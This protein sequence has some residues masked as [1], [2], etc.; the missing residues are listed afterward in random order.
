MLLCRPAFE[1][2]L[3]DQILKTIRLFP[4]A[5]YIYECLTDDN[6][7]NIKLNH[8]Q[9]TALKLNDQIGLSHEIP[10]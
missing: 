6:W 3:I 4:F 10:K 2:F 1:H 5:Y 9:N 8:R 7:L